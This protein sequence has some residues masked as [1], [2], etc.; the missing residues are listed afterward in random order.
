MN[1]NHILETINFYPPTHHVA[2]ILLTSHYL[3]K[4]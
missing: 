4:P 2:D 3:N 1:V